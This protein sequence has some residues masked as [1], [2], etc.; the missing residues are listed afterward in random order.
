MSCEY[1][2]TR[3]ADPRALKCPPPRAPGLLPRVGPPTRGFFVGAP[4][5]RPSRQHEGPGLGYRISGIAGHTPCQP[6]HRRGAIII[7][8]PD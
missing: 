7:E 4:F 5:R 3:T 8:Q 1:A 6:Y 2:F